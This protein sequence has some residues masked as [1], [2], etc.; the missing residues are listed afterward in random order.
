MEAIC[1]TMN[2]EAE[3]L[4]LIEWLIQLQDEEVLNRIREIKKESDNI[5][6]GY[7]LSGNARS[8]EET[9]SIYKMR[10]ERVEN[11]EGID[12]EQL[13]Q[14]AKSWGKSTK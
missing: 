4:R 12:L 2:L 7:D 13:K 9:K 10:V 14:E 3:K 6:L 5:T 1:L 11:G 8:V